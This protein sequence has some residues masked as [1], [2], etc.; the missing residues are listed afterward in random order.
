MFKDL[1][2]R[3]ILHL[4]TTAIKMLKGFSDSASR[5]MPKSVES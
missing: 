1:L 5:G 3:Q 4:Y 2:K